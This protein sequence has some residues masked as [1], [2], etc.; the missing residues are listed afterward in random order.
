MRFAVVGAGAI[1]GFL[2]ARLALAGEDVTFVARG[3]NLEAIRRNGFRLI[4][5]DGRERVAQRRQ[6]LAHRSRRATSMSFSW[7]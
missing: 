4:E 2:G 1:G 7:P 6:G 5:E 3:A